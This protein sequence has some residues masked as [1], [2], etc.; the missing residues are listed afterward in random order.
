VTATLGLEAVGTGCGL[1]IGLL[2]AEEEWVVVVKPVGSTSCFLR[3]QR[4]LEILVPMLVEN[5]Q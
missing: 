4:M 2:E 1:K 3:Q 5:K